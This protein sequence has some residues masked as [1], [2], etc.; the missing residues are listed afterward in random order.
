MTPCVR[1]TAAQVRQALFR[2]GCSTHQACGRC[3]RVV[4]GRGVCV[5]R[6]NFCAPGVSNRGDI[7]LLSAFSRVA[8]AVSL[9]CSKA[10]QSAPP[11]PCWNRHAPAGTSTQPRKPGLTHTAPFPTMRPIALSG[12]SRALTHVKYSTEGDLL[13]SAAKDHSPSLWWSHNGERIGSYD[14]EFGWS[15]ACTR[16]GPRVPVAGARR[17]GRRREPTLPVARAT[18]LL[19]FLPT[20]IAAL[21]SG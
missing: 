19:P 3:S 16:T 8:V 2:Q 21:A 13:F 4:R 1:W 14:G 9:V 11:P 15:P 18:A 10:S 7:Y 20:V 17:E 5:V 12:H 6:A